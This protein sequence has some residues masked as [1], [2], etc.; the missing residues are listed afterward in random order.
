MWNSIKLV[1]SMRIS[2]TNPRSYSIPQLL[3][4]LLKHEELILRLISLSNRSRRFI[5]SIIDYFSKWAPYWSQKLKSLVWLTSSN[6]MS[7]INLVFSGGHPW[8]WSSICEP[9]ILSVLQQIPNTEYSFDYV[10]P[11]ADEL[12]EVF[13][14]TI[15][16]LL[17]KFV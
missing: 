14:K 5:L 11:S 13:N 2:Y 3:H 12:A 15:I 10:R 17:K 1:K 8:K 6:T 16:K 4:S 9:I 7:F